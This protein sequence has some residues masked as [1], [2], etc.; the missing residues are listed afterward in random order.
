[1]TCFRLVGGETL[2]HYC[3]RN[4]FAYSPIWELLDEGYSMEEAL[5]TTGKRRG[6]HNFSKIFYKGKPLRSI[7]DN[8]RYY[9]IY[10]K[11]KI[12]KMTCEEAV[13][14]DE[15]KHGELK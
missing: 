1:M 12:Y 6:R 4:K 9:R 13:K 3:V 15:L 7:C 8:A 2:H 5:E 10:R 11:M 14:K